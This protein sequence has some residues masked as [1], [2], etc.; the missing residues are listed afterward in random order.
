MSGWFEAVRCGE[1]AAQ[2]CVVVPGPV[3]VGAECA[4][5][6]AHLR[7]GLGEPADEYEAAEALFRLRF[8]DGWGCEECGHLRWTHLRVRPRVFECNRCGRA[9]SVTAGTALHRCRLPL[10]KVVA[11]AR[12]L[13]RARVSVSARSLSR[14]L[15]VGLEAAWALGHR[16]RVGFLDA[17]PVHLGDDVVLSQTFFR[18]RKEKGERPLGPARPSAQFTVAWDWTQRGAGITGSLERFEA[19]RFLDRHTT[20]AKPNWGPLMFTEPDIIGNLTH[21]GVSERWLPLYVAAILGWRNARID[22]RDPPSVV[23]TS[24]LGCAR[25]P[26]R[27]VRPELPWARP[28]DLASQERAARHLRRLWHAS[29]QATLGAEVFERHTTTCAAPPARCG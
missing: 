15:D 16:L 6:P 7:D 18:R 22:G 26:F 2:R 17:P 19:R 29:V 28:T 24:A 1:E 23:L 5:A 10:V 8:R 3:G 20:D 12:L 14:I 9:H 4:P 27:R 11:A 25:F 21:R 13:C